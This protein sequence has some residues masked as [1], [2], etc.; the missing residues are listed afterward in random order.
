MNIRRAIG[1]DGGSVAREANGALGDLGTLIPFVLG[2]IS[3]GILMPAPVFLGFACGYLVVAVV[4]R[5][6]IAV[7][8]MKALGAVALT[9]GLAAADV[10]VA[11]AIIGVSLLALAASPGFDRLCRAIPQTVIV[12]LQVGLGLLLGHAALGLMGADWLTGLGAILLLSLTFIWRGVPWVLIIVIG[13]IALG[14]ADGAAA[15]EMPEMRDGLDLGRALAVGVLPQLPLTLLNAVVVAA[16]L[17]RSLHGPGAARVTERRLAI[18]SGALNLALAPLGALPM[19]HG[20][21]GVA[22]HHRFGARTALAPLLL[23]AAF[24]AAA[25]FGEA[26]ADLLARIPM[27]VV[28][29]L[30]LYAAADLA[31]SRR[32]LDARPDCRPVIATAAVGTVIGTA[33]LGFAAG[34]AA[35][36]IRARIARRRRA[37]E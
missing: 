27:P 32:L 5:I 9:G 26:A 28:G 20:A 11:G 6:P 21:G 16:A 31:F 8:P 33:A 1:V 22:A 23:A 13:A 3:A 35:E 29:A 30:L 2:A 34:L 17:A 10:A 25:M 15:P 14:G 12:G 36:T 19:C 37:G 24:L 4:Y 18:T 7:Q